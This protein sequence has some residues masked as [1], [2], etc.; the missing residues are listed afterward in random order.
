MFI[1]RQRSET[2]LKSDEWPNQY[3]DG[4]RDLG[5]A[6]TLKEGAIDALACADLD[7]KIRLTRATAKAW[8]AG[9]I[10]QGAGRKD[11]YDGLF[12]MYDGVGEEVGKLIKFLIDFKS[13]AQ[14][15]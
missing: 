8:Y 12:E 13:T 10:G 2:L 11:D 14:D 3:R 1:D 15:G 5:S 4:S 9:S 6:S 7:R